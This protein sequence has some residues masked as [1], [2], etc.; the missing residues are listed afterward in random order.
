MQ[1]HQQAA[2]GLSTIV[3][4]GAAIAWAKVA[5][6]THPMSLSAALM[7]TAIA[8]CVVIASARVD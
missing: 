2:R 1:R 6:S 3:L 8:A 4:A 5:M 7:W